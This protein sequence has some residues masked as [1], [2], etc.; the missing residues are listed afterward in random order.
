[1]LLTVGSMIINQLYIFNDMSLNTN[2]HNVSWD[3]IEHNY[4]EQWESTVL[5]GGESLFFT[6]SFL[7]ANI[8]TLL[9]K[10]NKH[11]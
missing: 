2:T 10:R 6:Q 8:V 1:M 3:F 5:A 11:D 7:A 9:S 4:R